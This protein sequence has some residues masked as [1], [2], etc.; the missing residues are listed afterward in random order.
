MLQTLGI[1]EFFVVVCFSLTEKKSFVHCP[2]PRIRLLLLPY[3]KSIFLLS[4]LSARL[5]ILS[6]TAGL[7]CT[8][9]S[10]A[11]LFTNSFP[12]IP[13][14]PFTQP[15]CVIHFKCVSAIILFLMNSVNRFR[16]NLFCNKS[17][18]ILLSVYI[19]SRL[20][21]SC[22]S[23]SSSNFYKAFKVAI[24]SA[25]LLEQCPYILN[26]GWCT[27]LPFT[28]NSCCS[29]VVSNFTAV[30]LHFGW[31]YITVLHFTNCR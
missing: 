16:L 9:A 8:A 29:N 18:V 19:A 24:C 10:F 5:G 23:C 2:L 21:L 4:R 26:F 6:Y 31:T 7:Y 14:C 20:S 11:S 22:P 12:S 13:A 3:M 30:S 27:N 28:N 15:K 25:W 1:K 17:K